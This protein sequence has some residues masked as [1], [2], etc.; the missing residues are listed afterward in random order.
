MSINPDIRDQA[1]QFFVEE[2]PE[3]LQTIESGLLALREHRD[4]NTVH[5][6]MRAAHSLK[7]GAASVGLDAI[8]QIAHRLETLFKALYSDSITI[9]AE[10][11]THLLAAYDVLQM[12][13]TQAIAAQ[14]L[15]EAIAL[16]AAEAILAPLEKKFDAAIRE[17][18]DF[19]P[20]SA[21]LGFSMA[22]SIFEVD[23]AEGIRRI[24]T[25]MAETPENIAG[26][27]RA[28]AEVFV[29]F[30]ELLNLPKFGAIAQAAMT[31]VTNHPEQAIVVAALA[32]ADL[33]AGRTAIL[34]GRPVGPPSPA[35]IEFGASHPAPIAE[36]VA[37][38]TV[39]VPTPTSADNLAAATSGPPEAAMA[40]LP[41]T[42]DFEAF[43][44]AEGL[45]ADREDSQ[46]APGLWDDLSDFLAPATE[47]T[48]ETAPDITPDI[49]PDTALGITSNILDESVDAQ[50]LDSE[51]LTETPSAEQLWDI[52]LGD[53]ETAAEIAVDAI[54]AI[55]AMEAA[56][57]EVPIPDGEGANGTAP[58]SLAPDPLPAPPSD[59]Q[60]DTT[61]APT[62]VNL[63]DETY[64]F[65][66]EE[67]PELLNT[68]E[69]GLLNLRQDGDRNT[70]HSI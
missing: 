63:Q 58:E 22:T 47:G 33:K 64:Q 40:E 66:V 18:R 67:A 19:V 15:D 44:A 1:Y 70:I 27:L 7:G 35:L 60:V 43:P 31:A 34:Q 14:P 24:E 16:E 62:P 49:A 13:L 3:L 2:A 56:S 54:D 29:G 52:A 20:T 69:T 42:A 41:A 6:I 10:L 59:D 26:E 65:F 9:D 45:D 21:D 39:E 68:V 30:A 4:N 28:Q 46:I 48:I 32:I 23:V 11:E 57:I 55:D 8:K 50:P 61:T 53:A 38:S 17:T 37:E 51:A 12:P 5:S 36:D 25:A